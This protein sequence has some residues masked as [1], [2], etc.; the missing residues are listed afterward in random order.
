M[1]DRQT[2][3]ETTPPHGEAA[4]DAD[5]LTSTQPTG[6]ADDIESP[7]HRPNLRDD[8]EHAGYDRAGGGGV[9][10]DGA[11]DDGGTRGTGGSAREQDV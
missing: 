1:T 4:N 3:P 2:D 8:V 5:T 11:G 9:I 10:D 6:A 7:S